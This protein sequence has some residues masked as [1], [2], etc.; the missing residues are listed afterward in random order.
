MTKN[1]PGNLPK[2]INGIKT[3]LEREPG[4]SYEYIITQLGQWFPE[5]S[6]L[7]H[8]PN[9]GSNM[10]QYI[11]RFDVLD[12]LLLIGMSQKVKQQSDTMEFTEA[13]KV[14]VQ[15]M[16]ELTYAIRSRTTQCRLLGL[17]A[18]VK[19]EKG[20]QVGGTW[21]I[22]K[23]GWKALRGEFIPAEVITFR[24]EIVDRTDKMMT[25]DMA[26]QSH[27][28][29]VDDE[30][31]KGNIPTSNHTHLIQE[32]NKF[33]WIHFGQTVQGKLL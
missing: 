20:K 32:F 4:A 2:F 13:N 12:A 23:K 24:N 22:T 17:V 33:D 15:K 3:I 8:C 29:K 5:I 27:L 21:L 1:N 9:C 11:F 6:D 31:A 10:K 14:H 19:N 25:I 28:K 16:N 18:K 26:L 7:E 30:H